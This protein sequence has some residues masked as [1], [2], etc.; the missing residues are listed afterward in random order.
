ML[1]FDA[2]FWGTSKRTCHPTLIINILAWGEL[3]SASPFSGREV[4]IMATDM[5]LID[6]CRELTSM[7]VQ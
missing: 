7:R 3:L 5:L 2:P 1:V 6:R 4:A